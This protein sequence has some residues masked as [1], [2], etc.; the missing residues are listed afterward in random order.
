MNEFEDKPK[1]PF[2]D[3]FFENQTLMRDLR[4]TLIVI[5]SIA[6]PFAYFA[7]GNQIT[8][9]TLLS[10]GP[11]LGVLSAITM[12]AVQSMRFDTATRAF[13]D[14]CESNKNIQDVDAKIVT[15]RQKIKNHDLGIEF[16]SEHNKRDRNS[17][18]KIKTEEKLQ[19]LDF[20]LVQL[21]A[22]GKAATKKCR[23]L[24]TRIASIRKNGLVDRRFKPITFA[25]FYQAESG[26]RRKS[27]H[28][29]NQELAFNPKTYGMT[30]S[31]AGSIVKSLGIGASGSFMFFLNESWQNILLYYGLLLGSIALTVITTYPKT[32]QLTK[33]RY[34]ASRKKVLSLLEQCNAYIASKEEELKQKAVE[35]EKKRE[36]EKL[37][38]NTKAEETIQ[39]TF[40]GL[41][42]LPVELIVATKVKSS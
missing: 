21:K 40:P 10:V 8:L 4:T 6:I 22:K 14:E 25:S 42:R 29:L 27:D 19:L 33:K 23:E 36:Q 2:F 30:K 16:T 9:E 31:V 32:R 24:E 35:D 18:N 1:E 28:N 12:L 11:K 17:L 41:P 39:N 3:R 26:E 13:E 5:I 20:K 38:M 15:E 34:L 37:Q 7:L